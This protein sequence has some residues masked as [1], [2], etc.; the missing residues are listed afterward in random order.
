[1]NKLEIVYVFLL[2]EL[3]FFC[4]PF[5]KFAN[6]V[7]IIVNL[8]HKSPNDFDKYCA[9]RKSTEFKAHR[10]KW[11]I[12]YLL[13]SLAYTASFFI[14]LFAAKELIFAFFGGFFIYTIVFA[15][16]EKREIKELN[17]IKTLRRFR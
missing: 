17:S 14:I 9:F 5:L 11:T 6:Y 7:K 2:G 12:R 10:K 15:I 4:I 8:I 1:M 13:I 16:A 3:L